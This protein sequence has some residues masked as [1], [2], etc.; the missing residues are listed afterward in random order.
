MVGL[1]PVYSGLDVPCIW[2]KHKRYG[3]ENLI[4]AYDNDN[5]SIGGSCVMIQ[6]IWI[7]MQELFDN[8]TFCDGS[9]V[10]KLDE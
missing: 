5:E 3:T 10:G 6:D 1:I 4:T 2:V 7:D 9:P 8:F